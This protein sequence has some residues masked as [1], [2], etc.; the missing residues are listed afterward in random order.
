MKYLRYPDLLEMNVVR[1]RMT[2][3]RLVDLQDFRQDV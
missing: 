1:S 2:L 3:K